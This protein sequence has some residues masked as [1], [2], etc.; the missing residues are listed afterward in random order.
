METEQKARKR[1]LVGFETEMLILDGNGAVSTRADELIEKAAATRLKYPV[2]KDYTHN[3]VEISSIANVKVTKGAQGW[4]QTVKRLM[5]IAK[6]M[7][8]RLYPFGTYHGT[9]VPSPRTDRYY[10]MCEDI[11]GPT[12][13][14][15]ST[16]HVL[17]F[18]LHYTL[19]YG[20]FNR[21]TSGLRQLF[22]SRYKEQLLNIYNAIVAIDPAVTNF[23]ESSPFVDGVFTAKDSRLFL[24]RAMRTSKGEK[25]IKGLYY[26]M[27]IFGRLPRYNPTISDL[28][29][30][31]EQRYNTWKERVEENHP[32]YLDIVESKHP[33][34]FNWGP[35]RINRVGTFEYRGMDMNL[36]SNLIGTSLLVKYFLNKVRNE[37]LTIKPSDIGIKEPFKIEGN[38]MHVPPYAYLSEV[39]QYKSALYG[40]QDDE[41]YKYTKNF[42]AL[43]MREVPLKKDPGLRKIEWMLKARKTK[44]DEILQEIEKAG[45]S[46]SEKLDEDFA[47][48]LAL[49]ACD[50]FEEETDR[51][52]DT[53]LAI[54]F[55]E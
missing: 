55:E 37:E 40:L 49:R 5:S 30:L 21:K 46:L 44:S 43:A 35:L 13:Y 24:Y 45:H 1:H 42:A 39:L 22:K 17:G 32:E 27:Q 38:V 23:M 12:R 18:H 2:H 29:L 26:D 41:V 47:R 19:P 11:M 50:E 51:L 54:D 4:L 15:F 31:I 33:L 10:R 9:H 34:Q 52:L 28:I 7:G 20:T 6:D 48:K 14:T 16:G 36:P 25:G 53:E 8:V 3:M